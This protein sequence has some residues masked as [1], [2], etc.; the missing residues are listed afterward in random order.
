MKILKNMLFSVILLILATSYAQKPTEVPKPSEKP[1][2]L[3]NPADIIIYIILPL[4]A[5]LLFFI[6]KG[7]QKRKNQ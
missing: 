5:V 7:K 2:D 3:T 6:W 4:C 1:I